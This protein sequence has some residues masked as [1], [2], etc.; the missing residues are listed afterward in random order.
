MVNDKTEY[1]TNQ[2]AAK[3]SEVQPGSNVTLE[4]AP[5]SRNVAK[6]EFSAP[7]IENTSGSTVK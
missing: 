2:S 4:T 5:D 1:L 6:F 3:L 7:A